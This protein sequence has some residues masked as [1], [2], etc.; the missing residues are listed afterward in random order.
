MSLFT[1]KKGQYVQ[2]TR[3]QIRRLRRTAEVNLLLE[4]SK[5]A[6]IT[7]TIMSA[8][9]AHLDRNGRKLSQ[10][11]LIAASLP[12]RSKLLAIANNLAEASTK[13]RGM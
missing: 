2:M 6:A 8:W 4:Q 10:Q 5:K 9:L 12:N 3:E 7:L 13:I 11:D 1:K